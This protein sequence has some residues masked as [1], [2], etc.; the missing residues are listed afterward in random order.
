MS[1]GIPYKVSKA[2]FQLRA[3]APPACTRVS[4]TSKSTS[5]GRAVSPTSVLLLVVSPEPLAH[6]REDLVGEVVQPARGET[7]IERGGEH[8][9][10][11]A[12]V[13]GGDGGPSSLARV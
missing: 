2:A 11:N 5:T 4:S 3:P 1:A 8:R 6:G 9:S 13:D 7:G 12:F 10:G